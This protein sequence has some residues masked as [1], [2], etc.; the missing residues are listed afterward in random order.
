MARGASSRLTSDAANGIPIW[1]PD[2]SRIVWA[3]NRGGS[4]Q[5]FQKLASGVGEEELLLQSNDR[6][7]PSDWSPDGQYIAYTVT[8]PASGY[9]LWLLPLASNARPVRY[10]SS[11]ANQIHA[12]FSPDGRLIAYD[13]NE[14]GRYEVLVQTF[15][16][17]DRQWTISTNGGYEPRWR[18]DGREIYYLSEDRKLM[19]VPVGQGPSFGVPKPLFQTRVPS[20]ASK[21]KR[22]WLAAEDGK[23]S[24]ESRGARSSSAISATAT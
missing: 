2:G 1:S 6:I 23:I 22:N 3:S 20:G 12:N 17:S 18:G 10:L 16:K 24:R 15:P 14:T 9:D 8:D 4:Y 19:A 11:P 7:F 21:R 5:F 13:S